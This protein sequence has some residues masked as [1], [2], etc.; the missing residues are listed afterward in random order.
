[1][2]HAS[3]KSAIVI[4]HGWNGRSE[5]WHPV[6]RLLEQKGC[7]VF[8]PQLPGFVDDTDKPWTL[9]D[10]VSWVRQYMEQ[11]NLKRV[12]L[13]GHS[14]GGR[15]AI[16]LAIKYPELIKRLV[17][18]A[19]GGVRSAPSWRRI[20]LKAAAKSGNVIVDVVGMGKY[21]QAIRRVFYRIIREPDYHHASKILKQTMVNIVE[22]DI[23]PLFRHVAQPTTLIWGT[24]DTLTP[25]WA[26]EKMHEMITGSRMVW[27]NGA[28]HGLPFTHTKALVREIVK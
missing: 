17:L 9:D 13:V 18:V 10:Y 1:M 26:G 12:V 19:S 7:V 24:E 22:E 14:N 5:T 28:R 25:P 23:S 27:V 20:L 3:K 4:L 8:V 2:K 16:K 15:I 21:K 11:H 6:K